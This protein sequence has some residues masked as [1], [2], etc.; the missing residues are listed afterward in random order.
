MPGDKQSEKL[1]ALN[2]S[3]DAEFREKVKQVNKRQKVVRDQ[4]SRVCLVVLNSH[5]FYIFSTTAKVVK[6]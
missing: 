1:L 6:Y 3:K 2:P 5:N 4:I